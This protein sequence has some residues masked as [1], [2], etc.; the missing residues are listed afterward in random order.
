[1]SR[2][3][4]SSLCVAAVVTLAVSGCGRPAADK[5]APAVIVIDGSSTVFPITEAVAEEFQ[6]KNPGMRVT[7]G[8]VRAPAAA[9][10]S[11]AAARPSSPKHRGRSALRDRGL[12]KGRHHVHRAAGRL[13]R[14][15]RRRESE[16]HLGDLDD[17]G[18]AQEA[19]GAGGAGQGHALESDAR[20]LAGPGNP[21]VRRRR[22]FGHVRLLHRGRSTARPRPAAAT[23]RRAR[24]TTSSC[25]AWRATRTPSATWAWRTTRR[26]RTSS[27]SS[28]ST[29]RSRTTA[30]VRSLRSFET[31]RGGTY[32][33]LSRPLFIYVNTAALDRPE[34]QEL[35]PVLRRCQTITLIR[36]VGYV[37]LADAERAARAH[38]VHEQDSGHDV[39]RRDVESQVTLEQRLKGQ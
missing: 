36:E 17:G 3:T 5:G 19:V 29:T 24:T 39:R 25:R 13:R 1:M 38:A 18:R 21:S 37:P 9:S 6:K 11:S 14:P 23:T 32:R 15:R 4:S 10:R 30:P 31:V 20:R 16:E 33:P 28:P 34:V 2:Y 12:R 8:H 35:R 26:T 27:S 22:R 7:V